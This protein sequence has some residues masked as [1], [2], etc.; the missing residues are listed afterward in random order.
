MILS[1]SKRTDIP[2]FYGEW[3]MNNLRKGEFLVRNPLFQKKVSRIPVDPLN[4]ECI[5]FWTKNPQPFFKYLEELER[6]YR[7]YFTYSLNDY[8]YTIERR[9]PSLK[10]RIENFVDLSKRLGAD[11]VIWRYDPIMFAEG[12]GVEYHLRAF[13]DLAK[14]L[15][16]FTK[17][18]VISVVDDYS[19]NHKN[20][21]N[22]G[23][24]IPERSE[25][26]RLMPELVRIAHC[27]QM[28]IQSCAENN[29]DAYGIPIGKCVDE[30]LINQ[31][32]NIN[33]VVPASNERPGCHC[34]ENVDVGAYNTCL[35]D[36]VYCYANTQHSTVLKNHSMHKM[37]SPLLVGELGNSDSVSEHRPKR[38]RKVVK[39]ESLDL[40]KE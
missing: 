13:S 18:V 5:V 26:D 33:L 20:M 25:L 39:N 36:C 31:V 10:Q 30:Q 6:N 15:Q 34:A 2:A 17:R 12:I 24:R 19:K 29:L 40:A 23:L 1:A 37:S 28:Q 8:P 9:L 22:A 35:H 21:V 38:Y 11:R 32:W 16:G 27:Y 4:V 14:E 7:F 3:F